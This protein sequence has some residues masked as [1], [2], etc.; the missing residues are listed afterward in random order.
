[1]LLGIPVL[2]VGISAGV[3]HDQYGHNDLLVN[4]RFETYPLIVNTYIHSC[5]IDTDKGAI[6]GFVAPMLAII[7]VRFDI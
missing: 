2:I 3:A 1:M 6:W 4:Y 5:W 7:I